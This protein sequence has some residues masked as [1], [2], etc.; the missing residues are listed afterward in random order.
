MPSIVVSLCNVQRRAMEKM[1]NA[2]SNRFEAL[3][4]RILLL[5]DQGKSVIETAEA[6]NC[7]RA[8]VYRTVYRFEDLGEEGLLD[9]RKRAKPR[10]VTA[11][12]CQCLLGYLERAPKDYGWQR[13]T[14]SLELLALQ[15][16]R[17]MGISVTPQHVGRVLRGK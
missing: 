11:Q 13:C 15:L 7:V 2:T 4:C 5:L 14:W 1:M 16:E 9:Q 12:A 3:R 8:T 10:K 17:D 6:A